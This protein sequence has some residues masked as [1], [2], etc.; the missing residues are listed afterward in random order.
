MGLWRP[1]AVWGGA[2]AGGAAGV[3]LGPRWA[4]GGIRGGEAGG[5]DGAGRSDWGRGEPGIDGH[6]SGSCRRRGCEN[7]AGGIGRRREEWGQR[8]GRLER[9]L[10]AGEPGAELR[11]WGGRRAVARW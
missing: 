7:W 10:A 6:L 2:S 9:R 3:R 11:R 1:R 5:L 4:G 8:L